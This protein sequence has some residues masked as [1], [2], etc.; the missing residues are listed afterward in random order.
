MYQ[1][2]AIINL[3]SLLDLS[4]RLYES[5]DTYF[6][7]NSTLL[8][9]M[10]K[11]KILRACVFVKDNNGEFSQTI[12]KGN[13]HINNL[14][15]NN[16]NGLLVINTESAGFSELF[17][18]GVRYLI[19][20]NIKNE[21]SSL[22]ILGSSF[23]EH[24]L[25]EDEIEYINLVS[26]IA[27]NAYQNAIMVNSFK[28]QKDKVER[29]NQL[30]TTLF[31]IGR[32]FSSFF[33]REQIIRTLTFNLMGQLAVSKFAVYWIDE[34]K[35]YNQ[36]T[37]RL[38]KSLE[39]E[40][41]ATLCC[42]SEIAVK[43][44]D[45]NLSPEQFLELN[46]IDIIIAA[47]MK[48]Q[49]NH[50]GLLLIGRKMS[51]G[52]FS[53]YDLLFIEA[54][55]NTAIA[56]LEN[57]RL[58]HQEL[59]KKRLESELSIA[60]EIQKNLLPKQAPILK[61][62]EIAGTTIPSRHVGGDYFDFIQLD[63]HKYL[64]AIADVSGK[65][66]PASLIMANMQSALRLLSKINFSLIEI[67]QQVNYLIFVNTSADKFVTG[68]FCIIDDE[69][70]DIEFVNAGHNPPMLIHNSGD[71]ELLHEGGLILGFLEGDFNYESK[72]LKLVQGET[73]LMF[74]D[75]VNEARNTSQ[76]EFSDETLKQ[77][78]INHHLLP[79]KELMNNVINDVK[80]FVG[81]ASQ[82][83]DITMVVLKGKDSSFNS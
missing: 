24:Q 53:D 34:H 82:Y 1:N 71:I 10:G 79:A 29:H 47:P 13:L 15:V 26:N 14:P 59:E 33:S 61:H 7:L 54:L 80:E 55:G 78:L 36:I 50:K 6:I 83:D 35:K 8:S 74:T 64:I 23:T 45:C 75:G 22:I 69:N 38:G 42:S 43:I 18:Y 52:E 44:E 32:D 68:F 21:L 12:T 40:F 5:N 17:N 19:P 9:L 20:L 72:K 66:I 70:G 37:N 76:E 58:F 73:I 57:E 2:T 39:Q 41:L 31:E 25:T 46:L 16:L 4:A 11:L 81:P 3:S 48:V 60:L 27:A 30:L 77:S 67:I 28:Q 49:G 56:A 62:F 51:G 63:E 65:G